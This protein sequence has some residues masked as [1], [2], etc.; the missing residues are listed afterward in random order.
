MVDRKPAG[1]EA[2]ADLWYIEAN[3]DLDAWHGGP[4]VGVTE[5]GS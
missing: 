1:T 2:P 5:I 4:L 3:V